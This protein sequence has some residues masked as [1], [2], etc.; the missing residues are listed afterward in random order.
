M[1]AINTPCSQKR[2]NGRFKREILGLRGSTER[3]GITFNISKTKVMVSGSQ[4]EPQK[5]KKDPCRVCGR[6]ASGNLVLCSK[7][8]NWVHGRFKNIK[9]FHK[10]GNV[11]YLFNM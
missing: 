8:E 9:R 4:G 10:V 1:R 3:K 7:C 5:S 6:R 2:H 11:F